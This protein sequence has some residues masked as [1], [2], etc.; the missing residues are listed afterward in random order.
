MFDHAG[1]SEACLFG[2]E[3]AER[4]VIVRT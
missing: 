4:K 1:L 3:P 2:S